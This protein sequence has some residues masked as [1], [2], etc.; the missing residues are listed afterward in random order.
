[1]R[2]YSAKLHLTTDEADLV[3]NHPNSPHLRIGNFT[4]NAISAFSQAFTQRREVV[5]GNSQSSSSG[6][7]KVEV[8][9]IDELNQLNF[10]DVCDIPDQRFHELDVHP[11]AYFFTH[12]REVANGLL[13]KGLN[14]LWLHVSE[15][16]IPL[17]D[18]KLANIMYYYHHP[19]QMPPHLTQ[20]I[21]TEVIKSIRKVDEYLNYYIQPLNK[22]YAAILFEAALKLRQAFLDLRVLFLVVY[23]ASL[24]ILYVGVL[25]PT[26]RSL[27]V[28]AEKTKSLILLLP[29]DAIHYAPSIHKYIDQ[30]INIQE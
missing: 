20:D 26:A 22:Y 24:L 25:A 9:H 2:R 6:A 23:C 12:C 21:V 16:L 1:M 17:L 5:F 11:G 13:Q 8:L 15:L 3:A 10:G 19:D 4:E 18:A 14:T 27:S 7:F 29:S 30:H 28:A